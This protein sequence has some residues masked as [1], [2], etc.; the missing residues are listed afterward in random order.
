MYKHFSSLAPV[1]DIWSISKNSFDLFILNHKIETDEHTM[2]EI[3][4]K[5]TAAISKTYK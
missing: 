3:D 2:A 4:L 5:W 1:N